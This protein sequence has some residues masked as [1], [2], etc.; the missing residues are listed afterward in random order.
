MLGQQ[1]I[2]VERTVQ[3][4]HVVGDAQIHFLSVQRI[5]HR[6]VAEPTSGEVDI[7]ARRTKAEPAIAEVARRVEGIRPEVAAVTALVWLPTR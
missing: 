4:G 6:T 2:N 1:V 7:I 5:A 3:L